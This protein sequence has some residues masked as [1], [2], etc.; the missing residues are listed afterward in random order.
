VRS[1]KADL[2]T[3]EKQKEAALGLAPGTLV[4]LNATSQSL[5]SGSSRRSGAL[6]A[7]EDLYR[8]ANTLA[9]GDNKPSEEAVD[10]VTGKINREYVHTAVAAL[11]ASR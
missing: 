10:R 7:S 1:T 11:R 9:Y 5:A 4:P 2:L 8:G 6:S 3:Y